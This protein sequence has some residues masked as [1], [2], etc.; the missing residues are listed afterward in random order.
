M[1]RTGNL[2]VGA[3]GGVHSGEDVVLTAVG[4][5]ASFFH[6]RIDNTRVFRG[7]VE[8]L[9]LGAAIPTPAR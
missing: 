5:G 6:G 7:I 2:P 1:R 8:A 3:R 9:G 4:P